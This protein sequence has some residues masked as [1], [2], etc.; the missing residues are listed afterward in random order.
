M[1][2]Y[3]PKTKSVI[4]RYQRPSKVKR[5]KHPRVVRVVPRKKTVGA[6][7]I[8]RNSDCVEV[9]IETVKEL[10]HLSQTVAAEQLGL[11]V[12]ALKH[13]CR[14][15]G[16]DKWPRDHND[17]IALELAAKKD[18]DGDNDADDADLTDDHD[19]ASSCDEVTEHIERQSGEVR[20]STPVKLEKGSQRLQGPFANL[21]IQGRSSDDE[22]MDKGPFTFLGSTAT[23]SKHKVET[24][25]HSLNQEPP[26]FVVFA[27][28]TRQTLGWASHQVGELEWDF[29]QDRPDLEDCIERSRQGRLA[30]ECDDD[31]VDSAF[32][33]HC[34]EHARLA[35]E[36]K[37]WSMVLE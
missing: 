15:L 35:R 10:S 28:G 30:M 23:T 13:A 22:G 3:D 27:G 26:E 12:T 16:F 33:Q 14:A 11:S 24:K 25:P 9:S 37:L 36:H 6:Q 20:V 21:D 18:G 31:F 19:S 29:G 4:T 7:K 32:G 8:E 2:E 17:V 1:R 5:E 34:L